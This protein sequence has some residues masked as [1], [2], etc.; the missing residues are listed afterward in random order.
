[1]MKIWRT[2]MAFIEE[3][4]ALVPTP[5]SSRAPGWSATSPDRYVSPAVQAQRDADA[6]RLLAAEY[7]SVEAARASSAALRRELP[8][9]KGDARGMLSGQL[10]RLDRGL[11][12]SPVTP[13][14]AAPRTV[15]PAEQA[16]QSGFITEGEALGNFISEEEATGIRPKTSTWERVK[17]DVGALLGIKGPVTAESIAQRGYDW[18]TKPTLDE[19]NSS[20]FERGQ[21]MTPPTKAEYAAAAPIRE[22]VGALPKP[23]LQ[24][25]RP[26]GAQVIARGAAGVVPQLS[27][28][29]TSTGKQVLTLPIYAAGYAYQRSQGVDSPTAAKLA[30]QNKDKLLPDTIFAP[31]RTIAENLGGEVKAAYE[32]N[33]VAWVMGQIGEVV[34]SGGE[35]AAS[36]LNVPPEHFAAITDEVMGLMGVHA[37]KPAVAKTIAARLEQMTGVTGRPGTGGFGGF[38]E[39]PRERVTPDMSGPQ[40]QAVIEAALE[41][42]SLLETAWPPMPEEVVAKKTKPLSP[43]KSVARQL[44]D[45]NPYVEP[46]AKVPGDLGPEPYHGPLLPEQPRGAYDFG[47]EPLQGPALP[48]WKVPD[49]PLRERP[50]V[51]AALEKQQNGL[52]VSAA[53]ATVL[54]KSGLDAKT[55]VPLVTAALDQL[56]EGKLITTEQAK[57]LRTLKLDI[58]RGEIKG[59]NGQTLF[60]RGKADPALLGVLSVLGLG[61]AMAPQLVDWWNNSGGLS[62]DN[63]RDVALGLG[64]AGAAGVMKP[65]GGMWKPDAVRRLGNSLFPGART[66][67]AFY[68]SLPE[69]LRDQK[70]INALAAA[71]RDIDWADQAITKY[72]NRYAG[73]AADPIKDLKLPDGRRFEE[74]T[75]LAFGSTTAEMA[76]RTGMAQLDPLIAEGK[77]SPAEPIYKLGGD[78][79]AKQ[80]G[81]AA[82]DVGSAVRHFTDYLAHVGDWIRAQNFTPE[83]L[84]RLDLPR[85]IRE[86]VLNDERIQKLAYEE[87]TKPNPDKIAN[88]DALPTYKTYAPKQEPARQFSFKNDK[89]TTNSE[90]KAIELKPEE[91]TYSW[92]EIAR[93]DSLTPEQAK[94]VRPNTGSLMSAVAPHVYEA[95]DA[96]GNPIKEN[97]S[98]QLALGDT[99]QDAYLAGELARE[100]N[101][102]A[103]CV[104]GYCAQVLSG[105]SKIYS[106]RDQ[107]GRSY[108]TVEVKPAPFVDEAT[109]K[110]D[111]REKVLNHPRSEIT[112]IYGPGNGAPA[113]Y[114]Q[115]YIA[116]FVKTGN[117][118]DVA[119][120]DHAGLIKN[121]RGEYLT[122]AEMLA[123]YETE[124]SP[125]AQAM[126]IAQERMEWLRKGKHLDYDY[127]GSLEYIKGQYGK[128]DPK[129]LAG[130]AAGTAAAAYLTNNPI[131]DFTKAALALVGRWA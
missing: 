62:G 35:A 67:R 2:D 41:K 11:A 99:P 19:S 66:D 128:A 52:L 114:V 1:M 38:A 82:G 125:E 25:D 124:L 33:P 54:R 48:Y 20:V 37:F 17:E 120:L 92:K 14:E 115:P 121:I 63:A 73:T 104:G 56:R 46:P 26:T 78:I 61:A 60:E 44:T 119:N 8:R 98:G 68:E 28:M 5:T 71:Q 31:W 118:G 79:A 43:M 32:K 47:P 75:D 103:H 55:T 53:E 64:A 89:S 51:L 13:I 50:L 101:A 22:R 49:V 127:A 36:K 116:D 40:V 16:S 80:A 85:A 126:G 12:G 100:G 107:L 58:S 106:L 77:I 83:Q 34:T 123:R 95:I 42:R 59:P 117:W 45:E 65:K 97:F 15:K 105:A 27:D 23:A 130:I 91:I 112:Q 113:K 6:G 39:A 24:S 4:D 109:R 94:R 84:A 110:R 9:V 131:D 102:M 86:T 122:P 29:L 21:K 96:K 111:F 129:L 88:N 90:T 69:P 10:E 18:L 108:A 76:S 30:M 74:L 72:L 81:H 70:A 7:P 93:P 3:N 87:Y 57:A